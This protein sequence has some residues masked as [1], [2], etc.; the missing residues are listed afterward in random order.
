MAWPAE[1]LDNEASDGADAIRTGPK[2]SAVQGPATS[3]AGTPVASIQR[4]VSFKLV[5][6][7]QELQGFGNQVNAHGS[8]SSALN[9]VSYRP[10]CL[11]TSVPLAG[12]P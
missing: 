10:A 5:S 4:G 12:A 11:S 2:G 1:Q 6:F 8:I 7:E 9:P 3:P